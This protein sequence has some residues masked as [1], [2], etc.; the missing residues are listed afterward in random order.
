MPQL[1]PFRDYNEH[2]VINVFAVSGY[3]AT[4]DTILNRGTLVKIAGNGFKLDEASNIEF[5]GNPSAF[6]PTNVV[7]QRY[8]AIP[9]VVPTTTGTS[10]MAIGMTLF[11]VRETD[12]NGE[13][14]KFR[15]RK[16]AELEAVISGQAVPIVRRG[17][18][19]YSGILT[20]SAQL[21]VTG[22]GQVA[23]GASLY[24]G[25]G[26]LTTYYSTGS[27]NPIPLNV[28][29]GVTM[30]ATDSRGFNVVYLNVL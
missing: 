12:E 26:A 21:A 4:T 29:V 11:D 27:G 9:K 13:L 2:D 28:K 1:G 10:D 30:G 18:F 7:S 6:S 25:A 5:L 15:P 20:G 14:L 16:A 23:A 24:P 3:T 8:G 17:L 22:A 19:A